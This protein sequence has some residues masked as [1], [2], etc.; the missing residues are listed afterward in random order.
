MVSWVCARDAL[1]WD[2]QEEKRNNHEIVLVGTFLQTNG[3]IGVLAAMC[4]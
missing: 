2:L 3:V 1:S 4:D